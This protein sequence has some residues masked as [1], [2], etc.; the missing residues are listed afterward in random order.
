M[1]WSRRAWLEVVVSTALN[2]TLAR[3]GAWVKGSPT[4]LET[5]AKRLKELNEAL[6]RRELTVVAWQTEVARHNQSVAVGDLVR[7]L[8]VDALT[9][10]FTYDSAL[11]ETA[12]PLLAGQP[13][14]HGWFV[15]LF[16]LRKSATILPHVHNHMV[17]AHLVLSGRFRARTYHRV[18][19][20]EAEVVLEPSIDRELG[21]G[22]IITMSDQR[23]N[24]HW[25]VALAD[26]SLTFDVGVVGLPESWPYGLKANAFNMIN[27]DPEHPADA[28]G[29]ILAPVM[30]FEACAAKFAPK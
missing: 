8:D 12:D 3:A 29:R 7:W 6:R 27:I 25:L 16:G 15:R 11:A 26:R 9:K 2:A 18:A 1:P 17:S 22:G 13:A 4:P 23:D 19:D 14:G 21:P 24:G 10:R 5:W 30:S 28:H 20:R